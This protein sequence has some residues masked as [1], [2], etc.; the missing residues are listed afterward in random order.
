MRSD[1]SSV[2][3][4]LLRL[5]VEN[6][7]RFDFMD[8][9]APESM[10][11]ALETLHYLGALTDEGDLTEL[12]EHM[13]EMPLDPQLAKCLL[14]SKDYNCVS[15]M[16]TITAMLSVPPFF[17]RP[18]QDTDE[19]DA[20]RSSF[21]HPAS[22]HIALFHVY[23]AFIAIEEDKQ[24]EWCDDHYINYRHIANALSVRQ[25]LGD[26]IV[27]Y[28]ID[29]TSGMEEEDPLFSISVR[30]CLCAGFFMQV[31]HREKNGSYLMI[32]DNQEVELH[33]SSNVRSKPK[34]VLFHS[35]KMTKK[36]YIQ[37]ITVVEGE[38]LIEL[39]PNYYD[40]TNFPPGAA[41][42]ELLGIIR[43]KEMGQQ[44]AYRQGFLNPKRRRI[45]YVCYKSETTNQKM[46]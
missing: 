15:T 36:N 41:R 43:R 2:V 26:M 16:L 4:T 17:L 45:W 7:V 10:M 37:T 18:S 33:Q 20:I 5:H 1:L 22:D 9:P 40:M 31:A 44:E 32:K 13:A 34:W 30:K 35:V 21:G 46:C 12:G 29:I 38:W 23:N 39:A 8:P 6:I 19:A 25:Q 3:L 14:V 24:K 11:R 42:E 27:R 28:G